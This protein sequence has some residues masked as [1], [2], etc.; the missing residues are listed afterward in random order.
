MIEYHQNLFTNTNIIVDLFAKE[1]LCHATLPANPPS[2]ILIFQAASP[3]SGKV[4]AGG[5][6]VI[7]RN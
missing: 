4:F 1:R 7:P 6:V 5:G 3:A 2:P